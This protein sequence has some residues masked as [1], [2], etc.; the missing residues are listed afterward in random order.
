MAD[1]PTRTI[2]PTHIS[3]WGM[4]SGL[5]T[6]MREHGAGATQPASLTWVANHAVYVPVIIRQLYIVRRV[7]WINGSVITTSNGCFAIYNPTGA[8]LY[9][10]GSTALSGASTPQYVSLGGTPI[11]LDPGLYYFGYA[12]DNTT[13]RAWGSALAVAN[14][15]MGGVIQQGS[16]FALPSP[17]TPAAATQSLA[18]YCGI[19]RT[20]SGF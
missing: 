14:L 9:T 2:G 15:R 11:R 3:T 13:N 6:V 18:P 12:C 5:A 19:T 4:D 7:W 16:A 10:T 17:W 1:F 8:R 20:A